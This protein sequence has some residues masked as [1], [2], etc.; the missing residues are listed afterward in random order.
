MKTAEEN[1]YDLWTQAIDLIDLNTQ[2]SEGYSYVINKLKERFSISL[3][4]QEKQPQE[5]KT[6]PNDAVEFGN[7]LAKNR[8]EFYSHQGYAII[9]NKRAEGI[10][11]PKLYELFRSEMAKKK[12]SPDK[13][14]ETK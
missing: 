4:P 7:W 12:Q 10:S 14:K 5:Q 13:R 9:N 11:V 8:A 3:S 2:K 6:E 1:Q